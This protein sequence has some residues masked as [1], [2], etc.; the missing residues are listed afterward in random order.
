VRQPLARASAVGT[1][2]ATC[3]FVCLHHD[4]C[5]YYHRPSSS[6]NAVCCSVLQCA[7]V[8]CGVLRCAAVCCSVLQCATVCCSV[9]QCAAVCCSMLPCV[10]VC[11]CVLPYVAA[12]Y[13]V[14]Q[15]VSAC[16]SVFGVSWCCTCNE[17][18]GESK[19]VESLLSFKL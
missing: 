16:G 15:Y 14:L 5:S 10:A 13:S 18:D 7:A 12:C 1:L 2:C 4:V 9:L 6:C 3:D 11:C 17:F 8:C 19:Y